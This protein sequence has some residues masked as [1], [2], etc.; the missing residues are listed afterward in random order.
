MTPKKTTAVKSRQ[1]RITPE[2]KRIIVEAF[3]M[4][5]GSIGFPPLDHA[6]QTL[7]EVL[8][9]DPLGSNSETR[10]RL[11][12]MVTLLDCIENSPE[13]TPEGLQEM[14]EKLK[15]LPFEF[16]TMMDETFKSIK[17]NLPHK[18]GGGRPSS[19]TLD[20][21]RE[22]CLKVGAL[23]GQG[24]SFPDA[25]TR[26]ARAFGVGKRTIQRAWQKRAELHKTR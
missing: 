18:P 7:E 5:L 1:N 13:P 14:L 22:A 12:A 8:R 6:R 26:V 17:R 15:S 20:Q 3:D 9:K 19:L 11:N 2:T 4:Q 16:R 10:I 24:V 25:L 21:K 23:I